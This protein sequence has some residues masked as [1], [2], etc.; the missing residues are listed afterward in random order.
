MWL[1]N[2]VPNRILFQKSNSNK[3]QIL[4]WKIEKNH[5]LKTQNENMY[6]TSP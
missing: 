5:D 2:K 3:F 4:I 1:E 6:Q